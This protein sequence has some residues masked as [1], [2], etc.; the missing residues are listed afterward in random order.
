MAGEKVHH[1]FLIVPRKTVS[2]RADEELGVFL[3]RAQQVVKAAHFLVGFPQTPP[4]EEI[5][6]L[7]QQQN[8]LGGAGDAKVG[9]FQTSADDA[10]GILLAVGRQFVFEVG[11]E[12][13]YKAARGGHGEAVFYRPQP[14][15]HGA[16]ARIARQPDVGGID[17]RAA[18]QVVEGA[19][20]VPSAPSAEPLAHQFELFAHHIVGV[21]A[22]GHG[23]FVAQLPV[24]VA[25]A[26][27][28]R[29][30]NQHHKTSA[31]EA[32]A[33]SLIKFVV[34]AVVAVAAGANDAGCRAGQ[35]VGYVEM[36]RDQASRPAGVE[37][38]FNA[39]PLLLHCAGDLSVEGRAAR[40]GA[41]GFGNGLAH[42]TLILDSLAA[43]ADAG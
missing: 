38:L 23:A 25:F 21:A 29:I 6:V 19:D 36:P 11:Q 17:F 43:S 41:K 32:L 4:V 15:G 16:T 34:F 27:V 2:L 5:V 7:S 31:G 30:V 22:V 24:L 39:I 28:E 3:G 1:G 33:K 37:D 12:S 14:S 40:A 9:Q 10:G 20:A 13:R 35:F 26:L 42:V 8:R 18:E